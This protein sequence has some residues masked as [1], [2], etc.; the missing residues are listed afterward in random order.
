MMVMEQLACE[1]LMPVM[2]RDPA[3]VLITCHALMDVPMALHVHRTAMFEYLGS[4]IQ[5]KTVRPIF[6][7]V[8]NRRPRLKLPHLETP[9]S[10]SSNLSS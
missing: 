7:V 4:C 5:A 1:V 3:P 10:Q 8:W 6:V 2:S 9:K